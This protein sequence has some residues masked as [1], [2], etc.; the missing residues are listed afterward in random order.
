M[1]MRTSHKV[2]GYV[3]LAVATLGA[4][5]QTMTDGRKTETRTTELHA[6]LAGINHL[7]IAT[8]IGDVTVQS[9]DVD[10]CQIVARVS[11]QAWT[12]R[13]ASALAEKVPVCV[14][15]IGGILHVK[16]LSPS[17]LGV[18]PY[19]IELAVVAP[20]NLALDCCT[21]VGDIR[22]SG[23]D[24]EVRARTNVGDIVCTD[25]R[26]AAKLHTD[27]G[28]I[29]AAY[30]KDAPPASNAEMKT[31]VGTI[32]LDRQTPISAMLTAAVRK[33]TID[34][35]R[36]LGIAGPVGKS[37]KVPMG[38]AEGQIDLRVT[39]RGSIEIQ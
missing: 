14:T 12:T 13:K 28:N 31:G 9:A 33:G 22:V 21:E 29:R 19:H 32:T 2:V 37:V 7:D 35:D 20:R 27:V 36:R 16:V 23:F 11:A 4:G 10:R 8:D 18:N 38:N 1:I 25:L 34:V 39:Q 24:E 26:A 15:S 5:C 17:S 30:A 3:L 6:P